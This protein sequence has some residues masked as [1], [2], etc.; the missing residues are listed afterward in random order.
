MEHDTPP[1]PSPRPTIQLLAA[2]ARAVIAVAVFAVIVGLLATSGCSECGTDTCE[3]IG[4]N[5]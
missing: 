5:Y 1:V 2:V 4:A 3:I